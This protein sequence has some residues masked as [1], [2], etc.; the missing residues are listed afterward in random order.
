MKGGAW[1]DPYG[2]PG[3]AHLSHSV[4]Y[5]IWLAKGFASSMGRE[6]AVKGLFLLP[7]T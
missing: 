4:P 5:T 6:W 3:I 2:L 1:F 7:Q